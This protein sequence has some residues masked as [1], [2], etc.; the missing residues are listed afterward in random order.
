MPQ[1][2]SL[3]RMGIPKGTGPNLIFRSA[4]H[5]MSKIG[6]QCKSH[7]LFVYFSVIFLQNGKRLTFCQSWLPNALFQYFSVTARKRRFPGVKRMRCVI[8]SKSIDVFYTI[9][10]ILRTLLLLLGKRGFPV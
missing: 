7:T 4:S 9:V 10:Q 5:L 8:I 6:S 1:A 2:G 3:R